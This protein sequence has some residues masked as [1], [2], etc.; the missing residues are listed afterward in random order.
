M[1]KRFKEVAFMMGFLVYLII[2]YLDSSKLSAG[3]RAFPMAVIGISVIVIALKLLTFRF[4]WLKFLDP[5]G[6]VAKSVIE[7]AGKDSGLVI[8]EPPR[9]EIDE[10]SEKKEGKPGS[11]AVVISL[12]ML[13]M[14]TFAVGIYLIGFLLTLALWLLIFLIGLSRIKPARALLLSVCTFAALYVCFVMLLGINFP[15]GILF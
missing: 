2:L 14:V 3:S 10:P 4:S 11:R 15:R 1:T 7:K 6:D 8:D 12:F 5:S 13:W 9:K